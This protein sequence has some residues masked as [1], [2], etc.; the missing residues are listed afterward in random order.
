MKSHS[1]ARQFDLSLALFVVLITGVA[2]GVFFTFHFFNS[3]ETYRAISLLQADPSPGQRSYLR[4]AETL[5]GIGS[6][7]AS[8]VAI[9]IE[10]RSE[11]AE[12][13]RV[14]QLSV[15]S[16]PFTMPEATEPAALGKPMTIAFDQFA[17]AARIGFANS[18]TISD[19]RVPPPIDHPPDGTS[20]DDG[21]VIAP[22]PEPATWM[23]MLS[24]GA[25]LIVAMRVRRRC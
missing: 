23:S 22:I 11:R 10:R 13:V 2:G 20:F 7:A 8:A 18:V 5:G 9:Q 3:A 12:P 14:A 15:P 16:A 17:S 21:G 19:P 25:L 6:V 1:S 4:G 24:G